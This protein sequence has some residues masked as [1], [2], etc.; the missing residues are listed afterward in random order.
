[1]HTFDEAL[2]V[3]TKETKSFRKKLPR[4]Q[5]SGS[6]PVGVWQYYYHVLHH[7]K[8]KIFFKYEFLNTLS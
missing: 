8:Y 5:P 2:S 7:F 6:T 4:V 3:S 1:M